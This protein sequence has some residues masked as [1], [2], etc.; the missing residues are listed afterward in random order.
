MTVCIFGA[1][2]DNIKKEYL[3]ETYEL[4]KTLGQAGHSLVFGAGSSGVMGASARG[5]KDGGGEVH[6]VIPY[7]FEE[8]GF[9][10]VF[11]GADRITRTE[12]MAERKTAMEDAC[13][14]FIIAPGGIGTL[15]EFFEVLTLK[16]L[17]RHKKAIIVFNS[18]GYYDKIKEFFEV[19]IKEGFVN[20]ECYKLFAVLDKKEEV[21]EYLSSYNS[22][23]ITWN[24]LKK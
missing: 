6:G 13:D 10:K 22:D 9:E 3:D 21:I 2:S 18:G 5:F 1:A 4:S 12:T 23:D 7:F 14:A 17:G 8:N 19:M 20:E 15:E 16:Q 24:I 11:Y